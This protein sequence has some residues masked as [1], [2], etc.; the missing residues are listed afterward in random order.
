MEEESQEQSQSVSNTERIISNPAMA[1][2]SQMSSMILQRYISNEEETS[3]IPSQEDLVKDFTEERNKSSNY[4]YRLMQQII[5]SIPSKSSLLAVREAQGNVFRISTSDM[6]GVSQVKLQMDQVG[7]PH[8]IN[9]HKQAS[10]V[11]YSNLLSSYLSKIKL[12][13]KA[14]KLEE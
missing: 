13:E 9:F 6:A 4:N 2:S 8:K 11:L 7:I 10:E 1:G 5:K 12:E 3:Q 14:I